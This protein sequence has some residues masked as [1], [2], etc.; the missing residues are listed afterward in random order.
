MP[1]IIRPARRECGRRLKEL[2]QIE[3][4]L[5]HGSFPR[6][7]LNA[8]LLVPCLAQFLPPPHGSWRATVDAADPLAAA[9]QRDHQAA[10]AAS[11]IQ[12]GLGPELRTREAGDAVAKISAIN[13]RRRRRRILQASELSFV[14]LKASSLRT[15]NRDSSC[16]TIP[17]LGIDRKSFCIKPR[18]FDGNHPYDRG[19]KKYKNMGPFAEKSALAH[20]KEFCR[21]KRG[22]RGKM[23]IFKL[24]LEPGLPPRI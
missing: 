14:F 1:K 18:S 22:R 16:R 19:R 23:A 10:N 3:F 5:G 13:P 6:R 11:K 24:Y 17:I 2:I 9:R 4:S 15:R 7:I 20:P 12:G 8:A 21:G